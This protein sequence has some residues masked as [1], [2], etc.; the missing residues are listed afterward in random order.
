M[1]DLTPLDVRKK[2]GDFAKVLRGYDQEEVDTFL[3]LVAERM[4]ELVREN[5][6]LRERSDRL[7]EQVN[8][9]EGRERAVQE[10]LVTA[11]E[12]REEVQ[13]QAE[14]EASLIR[15]EAEGE[16]RRIV[17]DAEGDVKERR[18]ALEDLERKRLRFLKSFRALLERELD[19][20][21]VEEGRAPLED[22][23]VELEL[24]GGWGS[25]RSDAVSGAGEAMGAPEATAPTEREPSRTEEESGKARVED[26]GSLGE[27]DVAA[28]DLDIW[29]DAGEPLPPLD[30][31]VHELAESA[32][33]DPEPPSD[34]RTGDPSPT[35]EAESP[36]DGPLPERHERPPHGG[37]L[38]VPAMLRDD[39]ESPGDEAG[40]EGVRE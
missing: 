27:P 16:A 28:A 26:S 35:A 30:A 4:E 31:P 19:V 29:S 7:L 11:Q 38:W 40:E 6:T 15:K 22:I 9:Q 33:P 2:K 39:D 21:E 5:I 25:A 20:V 10:A 23:E 24:G 18:K 36:G 8:S 32:G 34:P 17:L 3:D 37:D 1:I 12:L 14:R 13:A